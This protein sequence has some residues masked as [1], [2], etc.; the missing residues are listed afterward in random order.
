[1]KRCLKIAVIIIICSWLL[2]GLCHFLG[3]SYDITI[4]EFMLFYL[5]I[6]K[7]QEKIGKEK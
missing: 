5:V 4:I 1:M 3:L 2:W 6:D 7:L